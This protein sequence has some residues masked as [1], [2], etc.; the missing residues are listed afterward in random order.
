MGNS[1]YEH[2]QRNMTSSTPTIGKKVGRSRRSLGQHWQIPTFVIGLLVFLSAAVSA[3]WRHSPDW[4]EFDSLITSIQNG[5][6]QNPPGE[7]LI[8][9]AELALE[10]L[11]RFPSRSAETYFLAGSA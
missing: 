3:P 4:Y 5:L 11:A 7:D 9:N 8:A 6:D 2:R 1:L 10:R